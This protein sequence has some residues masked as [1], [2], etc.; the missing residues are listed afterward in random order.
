[1]EKGKDQGGSGGGGGRGVDT[2]NFC[3]NTLNDNLESHG[4]YTIQGWQIPY[5][6]DT[7]ESDVFLPSI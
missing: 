7:S 4:S 2:C 1:M 3:S 6:N 5:L